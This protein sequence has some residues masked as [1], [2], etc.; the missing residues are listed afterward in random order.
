MWCCGPGRGNMKTNTVVEVLV[1]LGLCKCSLRG[2][3]MSS[4][5]FHAFKLS[6]CARLILSCS[7]RLPAHS[8]RPPV[9]C[10]S[11]VTSVH[12][13]SSFWSS[14]SSSG[15]P[16][17]LDASHLAR[18]QG[19]PLIRICSNQERNSLSM[20]PME[21]DARMRINLDLSLED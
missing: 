17:S 18:F 10:S 20:L 3:T 11:F 9:P 8:C 6:L 5:A 13:I 15:H 7:P 14:S 12:I 21:T 4:A 1:V 16:S 2:R 19:V